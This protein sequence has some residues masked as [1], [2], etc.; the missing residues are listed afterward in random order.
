MY[1]KLGDISKNDKMLIIF[2]LLTKK[3]YF[4]ENVGIQQLFSTR[5]P[6]AFRKLLT[7]GLEGPDLITACVSAN[8]HLALK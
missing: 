5:G 8:R 7:R 6:G 3:I 2:R 1:V 4:G